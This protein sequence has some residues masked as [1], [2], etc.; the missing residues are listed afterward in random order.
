MGEWTGAALWCWFASEMDDD[1]GNE[2][3]QRIRVPVCMG[4]M[5]ACD[6]LVIEMI[7]KPALPEMVQ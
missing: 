6:T 3:H 7:A 4:L 1:L 5:C 2:T